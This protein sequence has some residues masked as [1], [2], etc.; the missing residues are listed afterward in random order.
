M[1]LTQLLNIS[2]VTRAAEVKDSAPRAEGT[3]VCRRFTTVETDWLQ[4]N[5]AEYTAAEAGEYL[6][7][8]AATVR[9][10]CLH[11]GLQLKYSECSHSNNTKPGLQ[12]ELAKAV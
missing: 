11:L 12:K 2:S 9:K 5:H 6:D 10:K 4:V 7:R 8:P 3:R 1:N